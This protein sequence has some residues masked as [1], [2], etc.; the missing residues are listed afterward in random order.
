MSAN[1]APDGGNMKRLS[2]ALVLSLLVA[3]GARAD[4]VPNLLSVTPDGPNFDFSYQFTVATSTRIDPVATN[5]ITCPGLGGKLV[6]CTPAGT[7]FT[8]YDIQGFQSVSASLPS[9]WTDIVQFNGLTPSTINGASIDDPTI[10]NVTFMYTGPVVFG[11]F[12]QSSFDIISSFGGV[13]TGV[14]TSQTTNNL[15]GVSDGTTLQTVGS[16]DVPLGSDGSTPVPEPASILLLGAGL[17]GIGA[18][19]RQNTRP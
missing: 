13:Q 17:I 18:K 4:G 19:T 15:S 6:Q 9:G 14:Y 16:V 12:F 5:G 7:F 3:A 1:H 11:P 2:F 8:I 10:V